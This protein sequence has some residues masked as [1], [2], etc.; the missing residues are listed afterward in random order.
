MVDQ[1]VGI[2]DLSIEESGDPRSETVVF[3]HG[4]GNSGSMWARHMAALSDHHC[5]APDLPGFGRSNHLPWQSRSH[6][7]SLIADLIQTRIPSQTAHVVGLSLG[8]AIAHTLLAQ[9]SNLL[10]HVIIDG[11]GVLP[12]WKTPLSKLGVALISPLLHT[13]PVLNTIARVFDLDEG[14]RADMRAASPRA[15]R[16]AFADAN[17][18]TITQAEIDSPSPTLLVAGESESKELRASNSALGDLMPNAQA[19]YL[20]GHGHGWIGKETQLHQHMVRAWITGSPLP[21]SLQAEETEWPRSKVESLLGETA[22]S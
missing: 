11:A 18:T 9:H 17:D 16:R 1:P 13:A 19:K 14:A 3:L 22:D 4:D 2:D 5:L 6:T 12:S 8:G 10:D 7:A 15:F 20:P 21:E